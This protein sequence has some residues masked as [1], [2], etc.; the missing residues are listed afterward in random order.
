MVALVVLALTAGTALAQDLQPRKGFRVEIVSPKSRAIV[1]GRETINVS[2]TEP[3]EG[4][5]VEVRFEVNDELIFVDTDPPWQ[6]EYD[7][8]T[9]RNQHVI[10]VVAKHRD[11]PT[12]SDFV[13]TRTLDLKYVVNVNRVIL[14]VSVRDDQRRPVLGLTEQDF[15]VEEEGEPQKLVE[16]SREERPLLIGILVDTSGSMRE[17]LEHA[18]T[19]ACGF[20][21]TLREQDRAFVVDFDEL[22]F[23]IEEPTNDF[24]RACAS[25]KTT[26]P[27]GGTAMFDALNAAY[28][29]IHEPK[30]ERRAMI[31]LSDGEDTES[32]LT[33]DEIEEEA[34]LSDVTIYS[35]GLDVPF[36]SGARRHLKD[37]AE[38]TGGRS[39]F[40]DDAEELAGTYE[41]IAEELRTQYQVTYASENE[42]FDGRFIEIDVEVVTDEGDDYDVRHRKGYFAV[43][44]DE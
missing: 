35:I 1:Q 37:L 38:L 29:V 16:V 7:F 11:G 28:R 41:E 18:Q 3:R 44:D 5:V 19:A 31:V 30:A 12:V 34:M 13:I 25:I 40:V 15:R 36:A 43:Q 14:T 24:D 21:E 20:L 26:K 8:G 33:F 32:R 22:V 2:V 27:V 10:R 39:Y 6:V 17:R 23:L 4:D 9:A 42:E